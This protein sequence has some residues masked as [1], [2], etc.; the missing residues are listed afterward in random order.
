MMC[1]ITA[2][3]LQRVTASFCFAAIFVMTGCVMVP[4]ETP[5]A[6]IQ[7][8]HD[9]QLSSGE[10]QAISETNW[11]GLPYGAEA[12]CTMTQ[13]LGVLT[14]KGLILSVY[15]NNTYTEVGRITNENVNCA[16]TVLGGGAEEIFTV[17]TQHMGVTLAVITPGGRVNVPAKIKFFDYLMSR[18]QPEFKGVTG[19]FIR[20]TDRK[21]TEGGYISGTTTTWHIQKEIMEVFDPCPPAV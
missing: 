13:G 7:I 6:K 1:Y 8:Q 2:V 11:C 10:I 15:K 5:E 17:F 16:K 3:T 18:G 14:N 19:G 9:L 20:E 4:Y 12:I 21:R